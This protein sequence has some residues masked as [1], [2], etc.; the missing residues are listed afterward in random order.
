MNNE[1]PN[2]TPKATE[3]WAPK[4]EYQDN[5]AQQVTDAATSRRL[6]TK[7]RVF[8][9][10]LGIGGLMVAI[11]FIGG[12]AWPHELG[13]GRSATCARSDFDEIQFLLN[14]AGYPLLLATGILGAT[15]RKT[16][17][18]TLGI[19]LIAIA[20]VMGLISFLL[21]VIKMLC[22]I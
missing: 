9:I 10:L 20:T 2:I 12:L 18:R 1:E 15:I 11:A 7:I 3:T 8:Y 5:K 13:S 6:N 14:L 16:T 21:S 17:I 22:G 4:K 19:I